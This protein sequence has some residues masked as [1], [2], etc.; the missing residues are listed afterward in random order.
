MRTHRY[1]QSI[2]KCKIKTQRTSN[3]KSIKKYLNTLLRNYKRNIRRYKRKVREIMNSQAYKK[4]IVLSLRNKDINISN[5][6]LRTLN[7]QHNALIVN[8]LKEVLRKMV[9]ESL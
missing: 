8:N 2:W 4:L 7:Q 1:L 6:S 5:H 3:K 9:L